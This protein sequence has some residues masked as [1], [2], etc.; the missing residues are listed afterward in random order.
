[1]K[2]IIL[3]KEINIMDDIKI[4]RLGGEVVVRK[5]ITDTGNTRMEET[6]R[7]QRRMEASSEGGQG[8]EGA[9][10]Q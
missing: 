3:Y 5:D 4:R 10:A 2:C 7:S 9:A 6:S 1:V 8:P